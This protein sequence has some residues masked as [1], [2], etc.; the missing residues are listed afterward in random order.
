MSL[1]PVLPDGVDV[2]LKCLSGDPRCG[3]KVPNSDTDLHDEETAA[4]WAEYHY[5]I[6]GHALFARTV[7]DT[8]QYRPPEENAS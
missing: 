1:Y 4:T 2:T 5:R 3:A 8:V 6:T 7:H